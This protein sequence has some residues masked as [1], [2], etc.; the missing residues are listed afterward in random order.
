ME[1]SNEKDMKLRNMRELVP[2]PLLRSALGLRLLFEAFL[3]GAGMEGAHCRVEAAPAFAAGCSVAVCIALTAVFAVLAAFVLA[4][5]PAPSA[6]AMSVAESLVGVVLVAAP[7]REMAVSA[8]L[9]LC[10]SNSCRC[11]PPPQKA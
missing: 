10:R 7:C 8:L 3:A 6:A 9:G 2:S 4:A 1:G 5:L 11:H